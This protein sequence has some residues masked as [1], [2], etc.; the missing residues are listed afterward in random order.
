MADLARRK[1][2]WTSTHPQGIA[3]PDATE[4][5]CSNRSRSHSETA[6]SRVAHRSNER[7]HERRLLDTMV[8][9]CYSAT[10]ALRLV[11]CRDCRSL[12][13]T[14]DGHRCLLAT[15]NVK[16]Y[17]RLYRKGDCRCERDAKPSHL[18]QGQH[19]LVRGLQTLVSKK[20]NPPA[21]RCGWAAWKHR[22]D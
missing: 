9:V 11:A 4:S 17:S 12:L 8:A 5:I 20:D 14:C 2:R 21:V 22:R 1:N 7:A 3:T 18:R 6:E 16:C 10:L 19:L 15:A 13:S